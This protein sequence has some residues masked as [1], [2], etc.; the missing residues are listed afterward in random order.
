MQAKHAHQELR[1]GKNQ[2][3]TDAQNVQ[4]KYV[5]ETKRDSRLSP[6]T[7]IQGLSWIFKEEIYK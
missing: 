1:F 6:W 3:T 4:S 5:D 2:I 7:D